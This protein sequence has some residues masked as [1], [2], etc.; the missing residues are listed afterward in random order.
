MKNYK[1]KF[2]EMKNEKVEIKNSVEELTAE[3]T[4][5]EERIR[6][7]YVWFGG[8]YT[9]YNTERQLLENMTKR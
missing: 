3:K 2:L 7:W 1:L 8:H 6:E 4:T 5:A 9:E